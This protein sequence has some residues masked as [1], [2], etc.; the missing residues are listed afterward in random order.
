MSNNNPTH[1]RRFR[2]LLDVAKRALGL[3]L[4]ILE[5]MKRLRDL[6]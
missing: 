6:L 2:R 5:I 1:H 3:V 4:V